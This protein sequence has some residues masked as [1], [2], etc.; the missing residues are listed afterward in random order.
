MFTRKSGILAL[1]LSVA[2]L[3]ACDD[4]EPLVVTPPATIQIQPNPVPALAANQPFT[5]VAITANAPAGSTVTWSSSNANITVTQAGVV[6]CT[7]AGAGQNATI[8]A[9][10][11]G[12]SPAVSAAVA[13]SCSGGGTIG[14][15]TISISR[16]TTPAGTDVNPAAV[17]GVVN[18]ITNVDIPAGVAASAMRVTVGGV[19]VCRTSFASGSGTS[20]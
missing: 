14:T 9:T 10:I 18:V 8:T 20:G 7:T 12:T 16:I 13:V 6:T 17:A 4:D 1:A 11:S 3:G 15:P 2:V 19:E 5:L